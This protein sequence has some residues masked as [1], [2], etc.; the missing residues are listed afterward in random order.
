MA[1]Q[2]HDLVPAVAAKPEPHRLVTIRPGAVVLLV[3]ALQLA[4]AAGLAWV[5]LALV[6]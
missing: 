3:V 2:A 5:I 1:D 4:W 6:R